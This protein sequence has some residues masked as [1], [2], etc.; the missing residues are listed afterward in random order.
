M[1]SLTLFFNRC[2]VVCS[3]CEDD[4]FMSEKCSTSRDRECTKCSVCKSG[5][6]MVAPCTENHDTQCACKS[7]FY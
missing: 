7:L 6:W 4:E 5:E 3:K 2:I 1:S